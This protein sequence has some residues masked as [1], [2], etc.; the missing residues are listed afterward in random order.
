VLINCTLY[1][2]MFMCM[3]ALVYGH[4]AMAVSLV[5]SIF[6]FSP[7][8][9]LL[10]LLLWFLHSLVCLLSPVSLYVSLFVFLCFCFLKYVL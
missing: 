5:I 8:L 2:C 3:C 1:G 9:L 10:L 7:L 6:F 4:F